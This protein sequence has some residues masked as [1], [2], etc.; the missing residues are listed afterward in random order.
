MAKV[1]RDVRIALGGVATKPWR[2]R[3]AEDGLRGQELSEELMRRAADAAFAG[4]KPRKFN[5]FKIQLGKETVIRA[6]MQAQA[7]E[8]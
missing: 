4:A 8:V 5:A 3:E 7:M 1:A 6:L 2:A